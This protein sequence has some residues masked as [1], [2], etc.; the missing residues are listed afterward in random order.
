MH[1]GENPL[2]TMY[3]KN[4]QHNTKFELNTGRFYYAEVE[5]YENM[6]C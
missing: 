5:N 3:G 4:R 1:L 2:I 6:N